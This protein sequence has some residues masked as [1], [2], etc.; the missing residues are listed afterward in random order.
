MTGAPYLSMITWPEHAHLGVVCHPK[1]N[2]WVC[3][4]FCIQATLVH[5]FHLPTEYIAYLVTESEASIFCRYRVTR[6]MGNL[7]KLQYD[8]V[9]RSLV[10]NVVCK[11]KPV[12]S[13][14]GLYSLKK[15][16][17]ALIS[18][19]W[20]VFI[21]ALDSTLVLKLAISN[22]IAWLLLLKNTLVFYG[23]VARLY[24]RYDLSLIHI[25]EP[26]RPY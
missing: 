5:N 25:S 9:W 19:F 1:V 24:V 4:N 26:T 20:D 11:Y 7:T 15:S 23:T 17:R 21:P 13:V 6:S 18:A 22:W 2:T 8:L 14:G 16:G 3:V 12:A 10:L